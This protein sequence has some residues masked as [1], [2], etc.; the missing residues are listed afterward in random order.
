MKESLDAERWN[1]EYRRG[2]YQG[3]PPIPFVATI[4]EELE[5]HPTEGPGLYVGCGN[6]R[7]FIP[8][9][10]AGLEL[11][12]MDIAEVAIDQLRQKALARGLGDI[13]A[14]T[15]VGDFVAGLPA[16]RPGHC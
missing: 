11:Q 1:N 13:T 12:G 16:W 9:L 3:E 8:L 7:N 2:R 6:G 10:E 4:I 5:N 15:F 14:S